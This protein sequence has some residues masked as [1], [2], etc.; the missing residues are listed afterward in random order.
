MADSA[1]AIYIQMLIVDDLASLPQALPSDRRDLRYLAPGYRK[2]RDRGAESLA[3]PSR[4]AVEADG[5]DLVLLVNAG[6]G[7]V[8]P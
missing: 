4:Q 1:R 5:V 2:P 7:E 6:L 3:G 8:L